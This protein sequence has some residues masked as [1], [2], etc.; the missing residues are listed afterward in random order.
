MV[1]LI[2]G[3]SQI[4]QTSRQSISGHQRTLSIWVSQSNVFIVFVLRK[5]LKCNGSPC[6]HCLGFIFWNLGICDYT[7]S[8]FIFLTEAHRLR[9]LYS[10]K[11]M[12]E[13]ERK[14]NI[15][16]SLSRAAMLSRKGIECDGRFRYLWA[17]KVVL[18]NYFFNDVYLKKSPA[19]KFYSHQYDL[20]WKL[21]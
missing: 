12:S 7:L 1:K 21:A 15:F 17:H 8:T 5:K 3:I 16:P 18:I 20:L 11:V 13:T 4:T 2:V 14:K 6:R 19:L 9:I 10:Q